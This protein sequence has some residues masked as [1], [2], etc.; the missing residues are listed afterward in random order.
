MM[1]LHAQLYIYV[2]F[3]FL[4][5]IGRVWCCCCHEMWLLMIETLGNHNH[6]DVV[7]ICVVFESFTKMGQNG[8]LWCSDVLVQVLYGFECL[9]MSINV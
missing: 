8:D 5:K 1:K 3:V 4:L 2:Y 9:F 6:R 7:W